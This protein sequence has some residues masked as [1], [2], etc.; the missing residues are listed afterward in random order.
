MREFGLLITL[1]LGSAT[2]AGCAPVLIGGAAAGVMVIHDR[3]SA[4]AVLDDEGLE[5]DI[6]NALYA[7]NLV[8]DQS[9]INV[10]SYNGVVLLTGET[11]TEAGK[12]KAQ[13]IAKNFRKTRK[14]INE[15]IT[16]APSSMTARTS[17]TLLTGKVKVRLT[18]VDGQ[19]F[20]PT[21]VKVVTE[22]GNVYLMGIVSQ[23]EAL[24]AAEAAREVRGVQ[25][26][27]KV[28]EIVDASGLR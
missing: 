9:H 26:V 18:H 12:T 24:A 7:E 17:D 13:T 25:R 21:R 4:G 5:L 10:T 14:V 3:R 22:R 6:I 16:A 23:Q 28:F 19:S 27:I 2:L 15:L 20:D 11:P 8:S 1:V